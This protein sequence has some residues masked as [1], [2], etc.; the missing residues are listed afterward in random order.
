MQTSRTSTP[1][2]HGPIAPSTLRA[3]RNLPAPQNSTSHRPA[4]PTKISHLP[5]KMKALVSPSKRFH[6]S[7]CQ[8][9]ERHETYQHHR[10]AP[11]LAPKNSH[12][13]KKMKALVSPSKQFHTS[14]CQHCERHG[15][16]QH[17]R[18]APAT[19]QHQHQ[20]IATCQRK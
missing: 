3:T 11:S 13:P 15:T 5:K 12:L 14:T 6:T 17:H 19:G 10:T 16:Y 7:T 8:H 20:K 1:A 9:C 18:T 4:Q 2:G